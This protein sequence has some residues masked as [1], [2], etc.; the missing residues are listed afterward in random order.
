MSDPY[1]DSA[2]STAT[3]AMLFYRDAV[4]EA[5]DAL[6][7]VYPYCASRIQ[8]QLAHQAHSLQEIL[9][10]DANDKYHRI[11]ETWR[12]DALR[13][14]KDKADTDQ[15]ILENEQLRREHRARENEYRARAQKAEAELAAARRWPRWIMPTVALLMWV[16]GFLCAQGC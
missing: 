5:R 13:G 1:R 7:L 9:D 15:L 8:D 6:W 10:T 11:A 2:D 14:G 3:V 12:K 4:K 16:G